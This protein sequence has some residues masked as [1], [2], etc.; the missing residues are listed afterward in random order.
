L[1]ILIILGEEYN[2]LRKIKHSLGSIRWI[3]IMKIA[4]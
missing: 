3:V 4:V 2:L 1:I